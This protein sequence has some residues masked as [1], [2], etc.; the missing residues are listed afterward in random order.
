M[1]GL[2]AKVAFSYQK[3]KDIWRRKETKEDLIVKTDKG[4]FW[5]PS[6]D[7]RLKEPHAAI[8]GITG[9]TC[10]V[11]FGK[12][13]SIESQREDTIP[14]SNNKRSPLNADLFGSV[15][16]TFQHGQFHKRYGDLTR[17]DA[18]LDI[19]SLSS[20]AKRVFK[21]SSSADKSQLSPRLNLIFQQQVEG[22]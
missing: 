12:D 15:C 3:S 9:G 2:C 13:S 17:V 21:G 20:F 6:Y 16:Y 4:S 19:F 5:R 22:Q 1:P 18:C 7:V 11:W 14:T 10:A 8:S